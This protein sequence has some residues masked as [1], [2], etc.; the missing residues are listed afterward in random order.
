MSRVIGIFP[1]QSQASACISDLKEAG[2]DRKDIIV[3]KFK[4]DEGEMDIAIKNETDAITGNE[5]FAEM[6]DLQGA[7]DGVIV[8]VE[9]PIYRRGVVAELMRQ[10]GVSDLRLD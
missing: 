4:D 10:R 9:V 2:F 8:S 7:G 1:D 3:S 5:T 6:N